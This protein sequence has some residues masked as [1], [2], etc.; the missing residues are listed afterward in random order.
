MINAQLK[1]KIHYR[2]IAY[3]SVNTAI[4]I[5]NKYA[6][7]RRRRQSCPLMVSPKLLVNDLRVP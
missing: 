6:R 2:Y 5:L 4:T 1:K 3:T 7:D